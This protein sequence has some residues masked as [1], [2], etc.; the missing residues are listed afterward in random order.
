[1][2]AQVI[3]HMAGPTRHLHFGDHGFKALGKEQD[4]NQVSKPGRAGGGGERHQL[5]FVVT[6]V[7]ATC[8]ISG[9]ISAGMGRTT[10]AQKHSALVEVELTL[11][12]PPA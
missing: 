12:P 10:G 5:L 2:W 9:E 6:C 11:P 1:M 3:L 7:G 8:G 4:L